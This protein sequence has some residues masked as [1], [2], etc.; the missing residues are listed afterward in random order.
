MLLRVR[1]LTEQLMM[2]GPRAASPALLCCYDW[3][4]W[5]PL[6][7]D[8]MW[9]SKKCNNNK[10]NDS[11]EQQQQQ[12]EQ[13]HKTLSPNLALH[14]AHCCW[15]R[16]DNEMNPKRTPGSS[17]QA[18][19]SREQTTDKRQETADNRQEKAKRIEGKT[20]GNTRA[21]HQQSKETVTKLVRKQ[22]QQQQ[23][24]IEE[25]QELR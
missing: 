11:S 19:D 5:L 21:K 18:R 25:I 9:G 2:S 13:S 7:K 10:D 23:L 16:F 20:K 4:A 22:Q 17:K 6:D 12:K 8:S 24:E 14:L 3:H 1:N 15:H